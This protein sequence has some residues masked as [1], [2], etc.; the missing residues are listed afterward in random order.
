MNPNLKTLVT[1]AIQI[2]GHFHSLG[3]NWGSKNNS[4]FNVGYLQQHQNIKSDFQKQMFYFYLNIYYYLH[5][6]NEEI[7]G[8]TK[9][10]KFPKSSQ[11]YQFLD[12]HLFLFLSFYP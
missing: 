6:T 9:M 5:C 11:F 12:V 8:F 3:I 2:S 4:H 10:C 1:A 7:W